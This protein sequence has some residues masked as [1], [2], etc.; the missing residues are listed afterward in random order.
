MRDG[1]M[2][3]SGGDRAHVPDE[4]V[5]EMLLYVGEAGNGLARNKRLAR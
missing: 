2:C 1:M 4:P 5:G 3:R